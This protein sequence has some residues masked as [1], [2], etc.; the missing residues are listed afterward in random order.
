MKLSE[1]IKFYMGST[2]AFKLQ[3]AFRLL[4]SFFKRRKKSF[5]IIVPGINIAN[6]L[7]KNEIVQHLFLKVDVEGYDETLIRNILPLKK[8]RFI[9]FITEL[10]I[11]FN[12]L[13]FLQEMNE[14]FYIF[15]LFYCPNPTRFNLIQPANFK[16]FINDDLKNRKYGYSDLFLLDRNTPDAEALINKLAKL[17]QKKDE[18][19]L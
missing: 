12:S 8:D 19:V 6:Y 16:T 14:H 17:K 11:D 18:M 2:L 13:A 1:Q 10:H 3:T 9:S 5:D 7:K 4:P 15:D